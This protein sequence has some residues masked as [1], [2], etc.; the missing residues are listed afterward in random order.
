MTAAIDVPGVGIQDDETFWA[1]VPGGAP[2][3]DADAREAHAREGRRLKDALRRAEL[4]EHT[5]DAIYRRELARSWDANAAAHLV[6]AQLARHEGDARREGMWLGHAWNA[7]AYA[8]SAERDG[9][10][11]AARATA[12]RMRCSWEETRLLIRIEESR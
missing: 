8:A 3:L 7:R 5:A 11:S 12:L 9:R 10:I 2:D 1:S 6:R 4:A